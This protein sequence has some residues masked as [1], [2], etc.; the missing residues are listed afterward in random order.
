MA[1]VGLKKGAKQMI[2][3]HHRQARPGVTADPL[4]GAAQPEGHPRKGQGPKL[5]HE[6]GGEIVLPHILIHEEEHEQDEEHPV[7]VDG[8]DAGL[9][10]VHAVEGPQACRD[11]GEVRALE[12][13]LGEH[14]HEGHHGHPE[15]GPHDPPAEGL[16]AEE[17][18]AQGDDELAQGRMGPLVDGQVVDVLI[19]GAGVVDLVEDHAVEVAGGFGH[20]VLLVHQ[21]QDGLVV[22]EYLQHRDGQPLPLREEGDL[23][24]GGL[25]L[26]H[27][28]PQIAGG[29][30]HVHLVPLEHV[31]LVL[32]VGVL[33]PVVGGEAEGALGD[34]AV[35]PD[36][37]EGD[38]PAEVQ[39]EALPRFPPVDRG[40]KGEGAQVQEGDEGV[41]QG[42]SP[43]QELVQLQH[44][45][46]LALFKEG[47]HIPVGSVYLAHLRS[48]SSMKS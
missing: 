3:Q 5:V 24:E 37:I 38:L 41:Y 22:I 6:G 4:A 19:G 14:I 36:L 8:G 11:E 47:Q 48:P 46:A 30:I 18:D 21:V 20:R 40:G 28:H 7:H 2:E 26:L 17:Q 42:Q 15:E 1:L 27:G 44:A 43:Q 13:A 16:H 12:D 34:V 33:R 29:H 31:P 35:E 45:L 10:E 23:V 9:G 32:G 25:P 39:R